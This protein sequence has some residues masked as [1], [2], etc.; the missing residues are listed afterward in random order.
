MIALN[1]CARLGNDLAKTDA[2][3]PAALYNT[4]AEFEYFISKSSRFSGFSSRIY[5]EK[6]STL[7]MCFI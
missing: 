6:G 1:Y 7:E 5:L 2:F 3:L 4:I